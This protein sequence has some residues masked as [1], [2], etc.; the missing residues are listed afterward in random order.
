[1]ALALRLGFV[2]LYPQVPPVDGD[3]RMYDEVGWNLAQGLGFVGGFAAAIDGVPL[4][5][6]IGIGPIYPLFLA[7][8]YT[9]FGH[10]PEAARIVQALLGAAT[11]PILFPLARAAFGERAA[12]LAGLLM[13]LYPALIV[14]SGMLLTETLFI[15]LLS[16][17]VRAVM[18]AI[19]SEFGWRWAA[20]G[21]AMGVVV[22][23][24]QETLLLIPAFGAVAP[25]SRL[26]RAAAARLSVF[27]V[28]ALLTIAP[29]TAR[30]YMVFGEFILASGHGGDTLWLST[31]DWT[32]WHYDDPEFQSLTLGLTYVEQNKVLR[33]AGIR[34][35]LAD[36]LGYA[37]LCFK[38]LP[39]FWV[40][41]HTS[42]LVGFTDTFS[43]YYDQGA[44]AKMTVKA[45]LLLLNLFVSCLGLWGMLGSARGGLRQADSVLLLAVPVV[46]IALV[47][48]FVFATPRYQVPI[49]P[50]LLIFAA[51]SIVTLSSREG[52]SM[53]DPRA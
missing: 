15:F 24:R 31:K 3:D 34:N 19:R 52:R 22:L 2:L 25:W 41:S 9:L 47:H 30:N 39:R 1:M 32:E 23:L 38:R 27:V 26:G 42:Y 29:W 44:V 46:V 10:H 28:A 17:T 36:P 18:G 35:I 12:R 37:L 21:V 45:L 51:G 14:Y 6:E 20:A 43:S 16:V 4:A 40:S 11:I 53:A 48:F 7:A 8:V 13:A 33:Q 49:L 5:P 50:F